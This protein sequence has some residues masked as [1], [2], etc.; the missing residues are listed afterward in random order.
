MN[1]RHTQRY[2]AKAKCR[3]ASKAAAQA[4]WLNKAE[5]RSYF[6]GPENVERVQSWR[7]RHPGYWRESGAS[8]TVGGRRELIGLRLIAYQKPLYH[9]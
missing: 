7:E 4:N 2:C 3:K 6:R 8:S 9:S 1:N 5:N